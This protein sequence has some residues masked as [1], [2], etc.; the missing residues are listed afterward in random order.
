MLMLGSIF[1]LVHAFPAER[2][3][4]ICKRKQRV[5]LES[6]VTILDLQPKIGFPNNFYL[7]LE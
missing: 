7:R 2:M 5:K 1:C 4:V 6:S 3:L